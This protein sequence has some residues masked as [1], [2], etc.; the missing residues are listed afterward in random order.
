MNK[1]LIPTLSVSGGIVLTALAASLIV[2]ASAEAATECNGISRY[3]DPKLTLKSLSTAENNLMYEGADG[4]TASAEEIKN[5]SSL[6]ALEVGGESTEEIR[7]VTE[8]I[9]NRVKSDSFPNTLNGVIFQQSDGYLQYSPAYQV[10]ETEPNDKITE[11]V[12]EVFTEGNEICDSDIYYF[13]AD[14]YH[15]WSGAVSE[16]NIGNTYFSSSIWAD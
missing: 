15:T 10:G 16:F 12:I 14:H 8:T 3:T 4:I 9:L 1:L 5:L 2:S 11:I 13:R 6:V 7:A